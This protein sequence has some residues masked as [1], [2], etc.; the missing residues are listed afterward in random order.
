MY[1]VQKEQETEAWGDTQGKQQMER[2][3][4]RSRTDEGLVFGA[5]SRLLSSIPDRVAG[6]ESQFAEFPQ[7]CLPSL[8]TD[9]RE[10]L[11]NVSDILWCKN[12]FL[13]CQKKTAWKTSSVILCLFYRSS[14]DYCYFWQVSH[15]KQGVQKVENHFWS[16]I[17]QRI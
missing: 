7:K 3:W 8:S 2:Q 13:N 6:Q 12:T 17:L 15:I 10:Y 5:P 9:E 16:L 14:Q 1:E 4:E 11:G